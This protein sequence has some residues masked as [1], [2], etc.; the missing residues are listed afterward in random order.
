L[1]ACALRSDDNTHVF[2]WCMYKAW[3]ACQFKGSRAVLK[4]LAV[5]MR[6]CAHDLKIS[7]FISSSRNII[8]RTSWRDIDRAMYSALVVDSATC[9]CN[10]E[11]QT[12]GQ[13]A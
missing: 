4:N 8:G 11:A 5:D 13:P 7:V 1:S 2:A 10:L 3:Q 6:G 9:E 12:M